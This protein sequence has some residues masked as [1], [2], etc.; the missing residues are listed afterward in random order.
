MSTVNGDIHVRRLYTWKV[1]AGQLSDK[2]QNPKE[3]K[4]RACSL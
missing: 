3:K 1:E 2:W 4:V